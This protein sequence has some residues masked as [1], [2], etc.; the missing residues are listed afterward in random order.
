MIILNLKKFKRDSF[1][2]KTIL[3]IKTI[4]KI[5]RYIITELNLKTFMIIN[6]KINNKMNK[7]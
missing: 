2:Y 7:D 4:N 3:M 6:F 5:I 1:S